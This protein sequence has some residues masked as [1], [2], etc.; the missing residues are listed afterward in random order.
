MAFKQI[1]R[2][3]TAVLAGLVP[4]TGTLSPAPRFLNDYGV[5]DNT[6]RKTLR[7]AAFAA[8][9]TGTRADP[10]ILDSGAMTALAAALASYTCLDLEGYSFKTATTLDLTLL[11]GFVLRGDGPAVAQWLYTGTGTAI[12]CLSTVTDGAPNQIMYCSIEGLQISGSPTG[13]SAATGLVLQHWHMSNLRE[14]SIINFTGIKL[15]FLHC[16]GVGAINLD[17]RGYGEETVTANYGVV[18]DADGSSNPS[19]FIE[20]YNFKGDNN[21]VGSIDLRNCFGVAFWGGFTEINTGYGIK[22]YA[23]SYDNIFY[24][25]DLEDNAGGDLYVLGRQNTFTNVTTTST[26]GIQ[27][28]NGSTNYFI[29]C[30]TTNMQIDA[31]CVSTVLD[32]VRLGYAGG[33]GTFTNNSTTTIIRLLTDV[34]GV[35]TGPLAAADKY[36]TYNSSG[37]QVGSEQL[38]FDLT[39]RT[40]AVGKVSGLG[41]VTAGSGGAT[42]QGDSFGGAYLL[43]ASGQLQYYYV[44]GTARANL[45]ANGLAIN[46]GVTGCGSGVGLYVAG[47]TAKFNGDVTIGVSTGTLNIGSGG[48]NIAGDTSG[49]LYFSSVSGQPM[50]FIAAGNYT[51]T[52]NATGISVGVTGATPARS[53][54]TLDVL[55]PAAVKSYTV[56]GLP[57]A[58]VAGRMA[59]ASDGRNVIQTTGTGTGQLV[60]DNGSAWIAVSTGLAVTA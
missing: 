52:A 1:L 24:G 4:A 21:V 16:V 43:A 32:G 30:A 57:A 34:F 58:G 26:T 13:S 20:F 35:P 33:S 10:F 3:F 15:E 14:V 37:Y 59:Y 60:F 31:P 9:G 44:G 18:V 36:V 2:K 50:Y 55:G 46:N 6:V 42:F 23:L 5:W 47:G 51:I 28:N 54:V 39:G 41:V 49:G 22:I 25:F 7:A 17:L 40:L 27:V 45:N 19:T 11:R 29:N 53:G 56:S 48:A 38:Q 8:S 12:Q